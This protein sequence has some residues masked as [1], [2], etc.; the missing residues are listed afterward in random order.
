MRNLLSFLAVFCILSLAKS[1]TVYREYVD[2]KI[3]VKFTQGAIKELTRENPRNIPLSKFPLLNKYI[4]KYGLYK[5]SIPFY[6]ASDDK[7]LTSILKLEFNNSQMVE[8]FAK[9]LRELAG[10]EYAEKVRLNKTHA[11]PNDPMF[12]T[13]NGSTH[14]NQI[15]AQ[16]AWNVFSGNSNIT[17]AIVDNAIMRTHADLAA[18]IYTNTLEASGTTGV[19]DDGNGYIDDVNGFDV[20]GWDAVT[21]PTNTSQ[22]HGT[23]CSGIAGG[24]SNNGIGIASI[25]W[26]IKI[27]PVKVSFDSSLPADIDFGY[28][29][30]IYAV[31][32]KVRIISCS[33]GNS[34][35][36]SQTE[37]SVIDYAWNRG[38]IVFA[39]AGNLSSS[40]PNY[41]GAYN[42]AFCVAAVNSSN[43]KSSY[44]NYGNWVDICA[45]G[46]NILSTT[47]YAAS[48]PSYLIYSGTSMA[49]PLTAGL[50][51]LMLSKS[52][53]MTQMDVLNCL[54]NTAV[55]IYTISGNSAYVSGSQ[56]GAGRIDAFAAMNCATTY[57][58]IPPVANFYA[59]LPGT[60]PNV[61]IPFIDS[62]LY[63]PTAWSWTFQGGTP[64]TSTLSSP[65]VL[66]TTA[67]TYSV[68]LTV[69]N[70][71]G[72]NTKTKLSYVTVSGPGTLPF[73][74]GF[75]ST[76]FLP[77]G[78]LANNIW[79]DNIYWER[80]TSV[81]GF[82]TSNA[83]AMFNNFM[84]NAPGE[85]DE[86][87]SPKFDLTNTA[88]ARLRFDVAYARYNSSFSD[89][90]EVKLS[91]D[92]GTTWTSIYLKGGT[93]LATVPDQT[94]QFVPGSTSWRRDTIDISSLAAGHTNVMF[95]FLNRGGYG[96][97]IYLDNINLAFPSPTLDA[98]Y[99][100]VV[101]A[102]TTL[103]FTN[104]SSSS[105]SY[106]WNFQGGAPATSTATNPSV[107]YNTPGT[108]TFNVLGTNATSTANITRTITVQSP[109][110]LTLVSSSSGTICSGSAVTLSVIGAASYSW[111]TGSQ[112]SSIVV[113]PG[114]STVYTVTGS[115]PVCSSQATI[116]VTVGSG[117]IAV[118]IN[119]P[120]TS[121]CFGQ[122]VVLNASGANSYTWNNNGPNTTSYTV[123]PTV[124]TDYTLTG[125][126][127]G[128]SGNAF[129]TLSVVPLPTSTI[130]TSNSTGC[131]DLCNGSLQVIS[132]GGGPFSY[133]LN[134]GTCSSFPCNNL[135]EGLYTLMTSN[136]GGCS[137]STLFSIS[138]PTPMQS[139]I[140]ST[141]PSCPSCSDGILTVTPSGGTVPY[142][143]TWTPPVSVTSTAANLAPGC[144]TI[145]IQ[146]NLHCNTL[147]TV[148]IAFGTGLP[149]N[150]VETFRI[151]PNPTEQFITIDYP[152]HTF[153]VKVINNLGQLI[154]E[155]TNVP[156]KHQISLETLVRGIYYIEIK[157]GSET[158]RQKQ[159]LK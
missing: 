143:Y 121:I 20:A 105:A 101:C 106:T 36:A 81:G 140:S 122:S 97:P 42:H 149:T 82:G 102:G 77:S 66:W 113:F 15:N 144:Y 80:N 118:A 26:N 92:C 104:I 37:Q 91:T 152:N 146:D 114:A 12:A 60:C 50:A 131:G 90:L 45:P 6:Q 123:A 23:H 151:Y 10:V 138:G 40:T 99:A 29:G 62:S 124:T 49:T 139:V 132:N 28:E 79:N 93:N 16:S 125:I 54:S 46:D 94:L 32:S 33:W 141:N 150:Q 21:N 52:P 136:S 115:T 18:N 120:S 31:R 58:A 39:S 2:G 130:T 56:L 63:A 137:S 75:Q 13:T 108:Y 59:F 145:A 70:A 95:S 119:S 67:G 155:N 35:G 110:I 61:S 1:Q 34:G 72:N 51:A 98:I 156:G 133:S 135:C 38:C 157:S 44:S 73:M 14:L 148:C 71:S 22:D 158:F 57:T 43:V 27:L 84:Y 53:N 69:S 129:L 89:T 76:S 107:T 30:I 48:T 8:D 147:S 55:N 47:P 153:D 86:M 87:R 74:E 9:E 116:G 126:S 3:Y 117:S 24:V 109:P 111:S 64:A 78:W 154:L 142:S 112:S 19:D 88:N 25:G 134:N 41:P 5:I 103:T 128:C 65:S 100:P 83:C 85:R 17:I 68:S 96:Q 159:V 11:V 127:G 7:V 4:S